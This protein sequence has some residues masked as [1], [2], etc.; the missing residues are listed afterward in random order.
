M[1]IAKILCNHDY[2]QLLNSFRAAEFLISF[3]IL[4]VVLTQ[5]EG[6]VSYALSERNRELKGGH[7]VVFHLE[8][9]T[10]YREDFE[11]LPLIL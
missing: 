6:S 5:T 11:I 10:I 4:F 9:L 2:R 3:Q 7:K 8:L 1:K